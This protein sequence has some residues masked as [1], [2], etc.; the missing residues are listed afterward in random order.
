[1]NYR[2]TKFGTQL[3]IIVLSSFVIISFTNQIHT[4][5]N[6]HSFNDLKR[7]SLDTS[8]TTEIIERPITYS[9]ERVKLSLEY[10]K[11]R[12][13]IIKNWPS[14]NPKIIVLHYTAGG[15]V[16]SNFNYFNKSIIENSRGYNLKHSSLNVSAHYIIDR[17]GKIYHLIADTLF[18]R[19]II[20]L[21]YCSIGIENI[22]SKDNPL[23]NKQV[24]SNAYL[25]RKLCKKYSIDYLIG[26]SE[27][28][29]FKK[30]PLWKEN[31]VNYFTQKDDPGKEFLI[32][33]RKQVS[34]LNLK[35]KP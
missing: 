13:G 20:G 7:T 21:N 19:H 10:L 8:N 4:P 24:L 16:N 32:K 30:S 3:I 1:M 25:I 27:Y 26:H 29:V 17:D 33:V 18:A 35:E 14:I 2:A 12:H 11:R 23:T 5:N 34:D 31:D 9:T 6:L 22:G 15:T 28:F